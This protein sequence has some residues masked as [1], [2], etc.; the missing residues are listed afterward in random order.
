MEAYHGVAKQRGYS[1]TQLALGYVRARWFVGAQII[2]ATSL[3]QLQED[4][5]A[6]Q[7]ELDAE[8]LADIEAVQVRFPNPAH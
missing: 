2:G 5:A 4:I 1:L 3:P 8:T 6:A 7:V